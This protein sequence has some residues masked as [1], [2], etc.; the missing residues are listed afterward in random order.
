MTPTLA[1]DAV[2]WIMAHT[3]SSMAKDACTQLS[4]IQAQT[5]S[6]KANNS[7]ARHKTCYYIAITNDTKIRRI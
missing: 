6:H 1:M 2:K 3:P 5:K 4:H 7:G